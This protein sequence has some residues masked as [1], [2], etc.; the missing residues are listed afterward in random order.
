MLE[1]I[2]E[3]IDKILRY[4][5]GLTRDTFDGDRKSVDAVVRNLEI[6]GEAANNLPKLYRDRHKQ[7]EWRQIIGLRHRVIHEYF[8]VDADII[9]AIV[10]NDLDPLKKQIVFLLDEERK[11][12]KTRS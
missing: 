4:T 9:W 2:L 1:D 12:G 5:S 3:S 8:D 11:D 6:I 7:V 10:K